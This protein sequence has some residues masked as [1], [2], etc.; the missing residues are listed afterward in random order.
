[1]RA[2]LPARVSVLRTATTVVVGVLFVGAFLLSSLVEWAR[3]TILDPAYVKPELQAV[4]LYQFLRQESFP[5]WLDRELDEFGLDEPQQRA[6]GVKVL[7]DVVSREELRQRTEH[8]V[9]EVLPFVA[10]RTDRM[11]VR[12][13]LSEWVLEVPQ[14]LA[15]LEFPSWVVDSVLAPKLR[16]ALQSLA[17]EPLHVPIQPDDAQAIAREIAPPAWVNAQV[18]GATHAVA[19]W[20]TGAQRTFEIRIDY[21]ERV[22]AATEVFKRLLR[23]SEV[24]GVIL[25]EVVIPMAE[26]GLNELPSIAEAVDRDQLRAAIRRK[27][28]EGWITRQVAGFIDAIGLWLTGSRQD[29]AYTV[30]TGELADVAEDIV[31]ELATQHMNE[32]AARIL[33]QPILEKVQRS[34][35][36]ETTWT[37]ENLRAAIGEEAFQELL[38]MRGFVTQGFTYDQDDLRRDLRGPLGLSDAEIDRI[39]HVLGPSYAYTEVD[40]A[41]RALGTDAEALLLRIRGAMRYELVAHVLTLFLLLALVLAAGPGTWRR[42]LFASGFIA[43]AGL[44]VWAG[45]APWL[46]SVLEARF[47]SIVPGHEQLGQHPFFDRLG[48]LVQDT[49]G[50]L[51]A[52]GRNV[53]SLAAVAMVLLALAAMRARTR[54]RS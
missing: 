40:L 14:S 26:Q 19:R 50:I 24:E 29:L 33:V 54:A 1:M 25:D 7:Q 13:N 20:A 30:Q 27:A 48:A 9:D 18:V 32:S 23:Q 15:G 21:S 22:D 4:G 49:A 52:W 28:P 35:P 43:V 42:G 3:N 46:A 34:F 31:M 37:T 11:T 5:A 47:L 41:S 8:V 2:R 6:F 36:E 53:F 10:R 51:A 12:P 45:L 39:R 16:P 44:A 38:R 17:G